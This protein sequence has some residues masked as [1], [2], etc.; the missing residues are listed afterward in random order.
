[1]LHPSPSL[2]D[3]SAARVFLVRW[4]K[5][6]MNEEEESKGVQIPR[7]RETPHL[8]AGRLSVKISVL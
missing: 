7:V 2:I 6:G 3:V 5:A 1:M 8:L 4:Y